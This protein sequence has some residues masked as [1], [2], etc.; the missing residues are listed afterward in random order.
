MELNGK[1]YTING[2]ITAGF[3]LSMRAFPEN[4][5]VCITIGQWNDVICH[6]GSAGLGMKAIGRLRPGV[7]LAQA[8]ADMEFI[9]NRLAQAYPVADKDSGVTIMS[10]RESMVGEIEP[11]LLLLLG[12][13]GFV[14]LIACVNV[15]NLSLARST[16]RT[17]EFA[18]RSALGATTP[19]V[20]RQLLTQ[21]T[22]LA[23]PGAR[24]VLLLPPC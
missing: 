21:S 13:V 17:R 4:N 16:S 18:I 19:R 12:A 20:L 22:L 6:D 9:T 5:E 1:G 23:F 7:T 10:L 8:R 3:H 14:L 15:A 24:L 2:V 11:F